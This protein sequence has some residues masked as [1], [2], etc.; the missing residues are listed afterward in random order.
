MVGG[1]AFFYNSIVVGAIACFALGCGGAPA[2][3]PPGAVEETAPP[4]VELGAPMDSQGT[5][6]QS[7]DGTGTP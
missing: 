4:T 3:P 7:P 5:P 1:R 6:T 2:E